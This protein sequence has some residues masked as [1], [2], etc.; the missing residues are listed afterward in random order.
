MK[1]AVKIG[2]GP[3]II[4]AG[5]L[6]TDCLNAEARPKRPIHSASGYRHYAISV[7]TGA[8]YKLII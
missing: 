1:G 5:K 3:F 7:L 2:V 6:P 4:A 8:I